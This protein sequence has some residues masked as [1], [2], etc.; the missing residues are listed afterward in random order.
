MDGISFTNSTITI[1]PAASATQ[2]QIDA[3]NAIIAAF[4]D[5]PEAQAAWESDQAKA[6]AHDSVDAIHA[7]AKLL[8]AFADILKDELNI[9][10]AWLT[11]WKAD[12]AAASSLAN[13]QTRMAANSDLPARTLAQLKTALKNRINDGTAEP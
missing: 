10:R 5:T 12:V 3:A 7:D 2:Q 1:D 6:T 13:L 4:A 9:L 11:D 8:R